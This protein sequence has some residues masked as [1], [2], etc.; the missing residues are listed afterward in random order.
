MAQ[1][2]PGGGER[3]KMNSNEYKCCVCEG[4]FEKGW[5]DEEAKKEKDELFGDVPLEDCC[6]VCDDCYKNMGLRKLVF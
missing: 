5:T 2:A 6:L 1:P 3:K 4:V